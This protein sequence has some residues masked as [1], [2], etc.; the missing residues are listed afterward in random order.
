MV[1]RVSWSAVLAGLLTLAAIGFAA[2][3]EPTLAVVLGL[4][5]ITWAILSL[6]DRT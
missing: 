2:L 1:R 5:A 4:S 3:E 6:K